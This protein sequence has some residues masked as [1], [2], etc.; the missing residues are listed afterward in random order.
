VVIRH[1]CSLSVFGLG[2][3]TDGP[4]SPPIVSHLART[5]GS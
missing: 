5:V 4:P 1:D 2:P 3:K